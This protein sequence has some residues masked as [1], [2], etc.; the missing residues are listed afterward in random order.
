MT[1]SLNDSY[2]PFCLAYTILRGLRCSGRP[3]HH[4]Y[5]G[6]GEAGRGEGMEKDMLVAI[7]IWAYVSLDIDHGSHRVVGELM[8]W[9]EPSFSA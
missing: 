1:P 4:E 2:L 9:Y 6:P 8:L 3:I 5:L 7:M